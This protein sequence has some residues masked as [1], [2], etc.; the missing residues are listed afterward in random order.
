MFGQFQ[1]QRVIDP[2]S[3][4]RCGR[5]GRA[6]L[7]RSCRRSPGC[8]WLRR[9]RA[10]VPTGPA[11]LDR[12]PRRCRTPPPPADADRPLRGDEGGAGGESRWAA[13]DPGL[14]AL[15]SR[16]GPQFQADSCSAAAVTVD[17]AL[18]QAAAAGAVDSVA[19]DVAALPHSARAR[20]GTAV[21][22]LAEWTAG[23]V[24]RHSAEVAA[25]VASVA[26]ATVTRNHQ[27]M[28]TVAGRVRW[29]AADDGQHRAMKGAGNS[30]G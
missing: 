14:P 3:P 4:L 2:L 16:G 7:A 12:P 11:R 22:D 1:F 26:Q 10:P 18:V 30:M 21:A 8:R 5:H 17:V 23:A 13:F 29:P 6:D 24:A 19:A 9:Y 28:G 15:S 25:D 27:W 20:T